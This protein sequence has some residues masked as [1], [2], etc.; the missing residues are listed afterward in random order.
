MEISPVRLA[1]DVFYCLSDDR[2][3]FL[4]LRRDKYL[5]LNERNTRIAA[6]LL[7]NASVPARLPSSER[8]GDADNNTERVYHAL[9][10]TG[11]ITDEEAAGKRAAIVEVQTPENPLTES[12]SEAGNVRLGHLSVFFRACIRASCKLRF[13][14]M[15]QTVRSIE[16]RKL[17]QTVS[18]TSSD[19]SLQELVTVFR[20]LRPY[21][22][23]KY[24]CLYDSLA[25]VEFLS[26][27]G[28]YP[29]WVFGVAVDPFN[30]HCWVQ[31]T[32]CVLN[33]SLEFVRRYTPIMVV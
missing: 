19:N 12:A 17:Q 3:V 21:Y 25:L 7:P 22:P 26:H 24:L 32:N 8:F 29:Q 20:H 13:Y 11:L 10:H 5:C 18:P 6:S 9:T 15:Q 30:A 23:R 27:Y 28:L 16:S 33:D 4:D 2:M 31:D 14:S 1:D